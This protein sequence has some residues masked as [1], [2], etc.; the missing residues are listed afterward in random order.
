MD[1]SEFKHRTQQLAV[2]VIKLAGTLSRDATAQA[3]AGQLLRSGTAIGVRYRTACREKSRAN[4]ATQMNHVAEAAEET[5]YWLELLAESGLV[6]PNPLG[7]LLQ[8]TQDD[9]EEV[10]SETA[11][12]ERAGGQS[13][14]F[15]L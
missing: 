7:P 14:D 9:L 2:R 13:A 6:K 1:E 4:D 5:V 12:G 10:V 3:L 8:D 15:K 11:T